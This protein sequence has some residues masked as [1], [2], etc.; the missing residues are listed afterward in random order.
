MQFSFLLS[1]KIY[2]ADISTA[3]LW[4][5]KRKP[6]RKLVTR[7]LVVRDANDV[8]FLKTQSQRRFG[9]QD[10]G[11]MDFTVTTMVEK[12]I[13]DDK[14]KSQ[15]RSNKAY[16]HIVEIVCKDCTS[17]R[18]DSTKNVINIKADKYRPMLI[19]D[20]KKSKS[21]R[22]KRRSPLCEDD[23]KTCCL[24]PLYVR[25]S[26]LMWDYWILAPSGFFANYCTGSCKGFNPAR[27]HH[28]SIVQFIGNQNITQCCSP[29][30]L[31]DLSMLYFDD[32]NT[33]IKNDMMNLRVEDCKCA[34]DLTQSTRSTS[35]R[36]VVDFYGR[37]TSKDNSERL[38]S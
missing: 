19:I 8:A 6:S 5:H 12:W 16:R 27:Y 1:S 15:G 9:Q 14:I 17:S 3:N 18:D 38:T 25:F 26:D 24:K 37:E 10:N 13:Q 30:R 4:V 33:I 31:S 28:T 29:S 7:T 20:L 36:S 22:R 23:T 21:K 34:W 2:K 35:K 32:N 11:W